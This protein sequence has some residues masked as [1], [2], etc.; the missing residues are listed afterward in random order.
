MVEQEFSSA[1]FFDA[2]NKQAAALR[3][4]AAE[5]ALT[6]MLAWL[7]KEEDN[8][9][10]DNC[11][12][13]APM[14][15]EAFKSE[16]CTRH[17]DIFSLNLEDIIRQE[18]TAAATPEQTKPPK[19]E[20]I[21]IFDATNSTNA[22][23]QWVLE[24]CTS[25]ERRVDKPTG[26]VF[27]ESICDDNELL[28]ENFKDKIANSPD[29]SSMPQEDAIADLQKR[30]Q[31]Y[32]E[33]YETID[34][35]AFSYI[36]IFNL[37][38][39][40]LV[41]H[42]Y[43]RMSKIIMPAMMAWNIGTRPIFLCRP[44]QTLGNITTD[45]EDYVRQVDTGQVDIL[46]MSR[47]SQRKFFRGDHLG[48]EGKAFSQALYEFC[49]DEGIAFRKKRT[50][51]IDMKSTGTSKTGLSTADYAKN[52]NNFPLQ[53]YTSTMPRAIET[54]R[55]E[56]GPRDIEESSSLNPLDKGDLAGQELNEIRNM[57]PAFY[58]QLEID[59]FHIRYVL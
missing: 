19:R 39:K 47:N 7:D 8:E 54:V 53:V 2:K 46:E 41:N 21:A 13:F 50:S 57:N 36:K 43:G 48:P 10:D 31:K 15:P 37:S 28:L 56:N 23:R 35:D 49:R 45:G 27:I 16:R 58:R 30:V 12:H 3:E 26:C 40:M 17:A 52:P 4:K 51:I 18:E 29:Y 1:D 38:T 14:N 42:I 33:Q 34:N 6:D 25:P 24:M 44:G 32:E 11:G 55:W 22:R 59:A 20:R 5:M 9:G